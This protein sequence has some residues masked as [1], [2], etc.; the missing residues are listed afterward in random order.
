MLKMIKQK[1]NKIRTRKSKHIEKET[2]TISKK[3]ER[4]KSKVDEHRN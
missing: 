3:K 4:R 2:R 1:A